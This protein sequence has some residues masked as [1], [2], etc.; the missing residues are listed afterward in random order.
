M[1]RPSN[2]FIYIRVPY[3]LKQELLETTKQSERYSSMSH[4]IKHWIEK[5]LEDY[6][7]ETTL[8]KM[9]EIDHGDS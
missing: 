2:D 7:R 9:E 1:A 6:R 3:S 5:G 8:S 4:F